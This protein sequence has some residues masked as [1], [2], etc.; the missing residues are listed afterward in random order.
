MMKGTQTAWASYLPAI[1]RKPQMRKLLISVAATA[2]LAALPALAQ[3]DHDHGPD[4]GGGGAP[5]APHGGP[6]GGGHAD[7]GGGAPH[8]QPSG[9][10]GF[11]RGANGG[12]SGRPVMTAPANNAAPAFSRGPNGGAAAQPRPQ[13]NPTH[14]RGPNGGF[15]PGGPNRPAAGGQGFNRGGAGSRHDFHGFADFHQSFNASRRFH[16]P[17]YRRPPGWYAHRWTFG[18]FLPAPFWAQD[19]W[20]ADYMDYALPPPPPYAVWVR[21]GADAL[22]IDQDSGEIITVEYGVFY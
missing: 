21:Y 8:P 18:E 11:S 14:A 3:P 1:F 22:L 9:N 20:L 6:P 19:Y 16:A 15:N 13:T 12:N 2:F 4:H 7:H 17:T 5:P 10:P